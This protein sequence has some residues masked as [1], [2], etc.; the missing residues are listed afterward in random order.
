MSFY[1]MKT[2]GRPRKDKALG[3]NK[4]VLYRR[5]KLYAFLKSFGAQNLSPQ[6]CE[7]N[8]SLLAS[9]GW[10]QELHLEAGLRYKA[11]QRKVVSIFEM[12]SLKISEVYSGTGDIAQSKKPV[13][14][15]EADCSQGIALQKKWREVQHLLR[16]TKPVVRRQAER[17]FSH[18]HLTIP[19]IV[20][21]KRS[22][23]RG[24]VVMFF[25]EL[26][27]ILVPSSSKMKEGKEQKQ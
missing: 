13:T 16:E 10:L 9:L 11:L 8:L 7:C 24:E 4:Q 15:V 5:T 1:H 18:V 3:P 12:P 25:S 22:T 20:E 6:V 19:E 17:I 27:N 21:Y 26:A 2:R 14:S 23:V